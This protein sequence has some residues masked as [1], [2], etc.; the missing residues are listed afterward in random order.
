MHDIHHLEKFFMYLK[1]AIEVLDDEKTRQYIGRLL[2][3]QGI[4]RDSY[5]THDIF[6]QK[7]RKLRR[8]YKEKCRYICDDKRECVF[9]VVG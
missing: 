1:G 4:P 8:L 2:G 3:I 9:G 7:I 5:K 6:W